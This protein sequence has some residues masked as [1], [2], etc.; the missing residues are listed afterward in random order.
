MKLVKDVEYE[1][2]ITESHNK[3]DEKTEVKEKK[4]Y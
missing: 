4:H 1:K 3:C 2:L